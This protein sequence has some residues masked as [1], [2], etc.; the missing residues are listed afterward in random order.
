MYAYCKP[1]RTVASIPLISHLQKPIK[2]TERL[3]IDLKRS[4]MCPCMLRTNKPR[5]TFK[6]L[7]IIIS[8]YGVVRIQLTNFSHHDCENAY[9][10]SYHHQIRRMTHLPLFKFRS[11]NNGMSCMAFD[12]RMNH[13]R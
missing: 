5:S 11:G 4:S 6:P 12:I 9:T 13:I 8:I 1:L 7:F 10:L 3:E 2:C